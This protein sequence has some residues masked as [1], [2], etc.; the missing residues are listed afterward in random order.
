MHPSNVPKS[1]YMYYKGLTSLVPVAEEKEDRVQ[2]VEVNGDA[3]KSSKKSKRKQRPKE[4]KPSKE[5]LKA[6][7]LDIEPN[8]KKK[9][10]RF[11]QW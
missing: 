2:V 1:K 6:Y 4:C 5:R 3:G 8:E 7:G 11:Q 10:N 9:K